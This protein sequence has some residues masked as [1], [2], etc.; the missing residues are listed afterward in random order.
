MHL[1]GRSRRTASA[2]TQAAYRRSHLAFYAKQHSGWVWLLRA[3][4]RLKGEPPPPT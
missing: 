3:Y 2:A 4:L 1:R